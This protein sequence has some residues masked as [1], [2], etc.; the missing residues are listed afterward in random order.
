MT[1]FAYTSGPARV[2]F[3]PGVLD[4]LPEE[5]RR[6]GRSR[7]LVRPLSAPVACCIM[8]AKSLVTTDSFGG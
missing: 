7:V 2:V 3:G 1:S 6:L 5:V 4:Q 8:D